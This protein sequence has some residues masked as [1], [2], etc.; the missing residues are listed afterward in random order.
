MSVLTNA[1]KYSFK[2][3]LPI[4]ISQIIL[5]AAVAAFFGLIYVFRGIFIFLMVSRIIVIIFAGLLFTTIYYLNTAVSFS[6]IEDK[7]NSGKIDFYSIFGRS[8]NRLFAFFGF[9]ILSC[10]FFVPIVGIILSLIFIFLLPYFISYM[11]LLILRDNGPIEAISSSYNLASGRYWYI[12]GQILLFVVVYLIV[13]FIGGGL[14]VAVSAAF[15][16]LQQ[17]RS[18]NPQA[19]IAVIKSPLFIFGGI[20]LLLISSIFT[21]FGKNYCIIIFKTLEGTMPDN[22][23]PEIAEAAADI[24]QTA[25]RQDIEPQFLPE[26]KNITPSASNPDNPEVPPHTTNGGMPYI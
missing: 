17:L 1:I 13:C 7:I 23:A 20:V 11:P 16:E 25:P 9:L 3:F 15:P 22:N 5:L 26:Q 4:L 18:N 8:M 12:W 19:I 2:T 14:F 6:I 21:T 24:G 10:I